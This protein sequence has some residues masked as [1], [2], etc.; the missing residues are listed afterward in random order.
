MSLNGWG[1]APSR[2]PAGSSGG[3]YGETGKSFGDQERSVT[4]AV[5]GGGTKT[6]TVSPQ[7]TF[8]QSWSGPKRFFGLTGGYRDLKTPGVTPERG[9]AYQS[10]W[11]GLGRGL[12]SIFGGIPGKIASGAMTA[13]NWA[14]QKGTG[15]LDEV[16]EFSNYPTLDRYLNR[17]TGKYDDKPYR[18]QGEGYNF[19]EGGRIGYRDGEFVEDVNIEGP[20]YDE[21]VMMASDP[22]AMDS[23]NELSKSLFEGRGVHE[24]TPEE[25][26]ILIDVAKS[27]A[28]GPEQDQ[29]LASLV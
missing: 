9:G 22:D 17:N 14:K 11:G 12:L 16:E 8:A 15:V 10:R 19:A 13:R 6:T 29:G 5:P 26:D 23:L 21:N 18:G 4:S 3:G 20:G 7:D 2:G 1:D 28:A 24:L 25:Y 27:Q